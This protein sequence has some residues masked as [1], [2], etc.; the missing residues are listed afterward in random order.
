[1]ER[2]FRATLSLEES[3][4]NRKRGR[5][6]NGPGT[7]RAGKTFEAVVNTGYAFI[8]LAIWGQIAF[9]LYVRVYV[10]LALIVPTPDYLSRC[11][12]KSLGIRDFTRQSSLYP[13]TW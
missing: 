5:G 4:V 1:M 12:L 7:G 10:R 9:P 3:R 2:C 6:R 8:L 13:D 11:H